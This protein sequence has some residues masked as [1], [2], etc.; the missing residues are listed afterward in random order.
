MEI[1]VQNINSKIKASHLSRD[2]Y[3]YV[4][5]STIHQVLNNTESTK[6]QYQL[7]ERTLELGWKTEQIKV[8]DC[9]QGKSA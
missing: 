1:Q 6:R 7:R 3:L 9:D 2:T 4:R 5:Q 8:I